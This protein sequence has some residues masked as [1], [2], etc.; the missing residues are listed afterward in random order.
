MQRKFFYM[1]SRRIIRMKVLH[2]LFSHTMQSNTSVF[3][4]EKDLDK[5]LQRFHELF[6]YLL[7]L[8]IETAKYSSSRLEI[9]RQKQ[10]PTKEDL[11]PNLR[12]VNNQL[13]KQLAENLALKT[14]LSKVEFSWKTSPDVVKQMFL[15]ISD[16]EVYK[17]Y[18]TSEISGYEV[19]KSF[20]L[21][22]FFEIF[23]NSETLYQHLEETD[24][25]WNDDIDFAIS[26]IVKMLKE[27]KIGFDQRAMLPKLYKQDDDR[28]FG[29]KLFRMVSVNQQKYHDL[30]EENIENW[31]LERV[32]F[33]DRL[34]ME[35]AIAEAVTFPSIPTKVTINEFL[36][37]A[38]MYS[39]E[40][41][42][43]FINGILDKIFNKLQKQGIIKKQGRGLLDK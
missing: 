3:Q 4:A 16:S 33:I 7:Q 17:N 2:I 25:F 14:Y 21:Y 5:S 11:N 36:D 34:I 10:L 42:S 30:I 24:L 22:V 8:V 13:I 35:L 23:Y 37:L 15:E 39:T 29:K 43:T 41:S 40:K 18:M 6:C 27:F 28:E 1:I 38:K 9:A 26:M 32:A 12:F 20:I 31:D 19:D